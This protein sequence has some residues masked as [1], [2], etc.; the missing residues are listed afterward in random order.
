MAKPVRHVPV[1]LA[2]AVELL[3][4]QPGGK[5]IDAT[6]GGG[7]HSAEILARGG[8]VLGMDWDKEALKAARK[9]LASEFPKGKWK[10][11]RGNF[12]K[13]FEAAEENGFAGADGVLMDLGVSSFQINTAARGFSLFQAPYRF[14]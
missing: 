14:S 8:E 7:G 9:N 1:L 11:A 13:I 6:G 2:E 5:Y 4:V 10:L 12:A 3:A